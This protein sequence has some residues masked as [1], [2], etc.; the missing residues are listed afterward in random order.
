MSM[1]VIWV[2]RSYGN[3]MNLKQHQIELQ[4]IVKDEYYESDEDDTK[5]AKEDIIH[6]QE[7]DDSF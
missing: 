2:N 4:T 3:Y 7:D 6:I 1:D 5:E